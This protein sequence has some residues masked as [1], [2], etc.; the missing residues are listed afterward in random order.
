MN[1]DVRT[2]AARSRG[3]EVEMV[4][5]V[6]GIHYYIEARWYCGTTTATGPDPDE[7]ESIRVYCGGPHGAE[8]DY[9][10]FLRVYGAEHDLELD[11]SDEA[12]IARIAKEARR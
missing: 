1:N 2:R 8:V 5:T 7:I 11:A 10:E 4:E 3:R 9:D 6:E 12:I